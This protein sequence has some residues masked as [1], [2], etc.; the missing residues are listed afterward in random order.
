LFP[1]AVG[2][3]TI[4]SNVIA[5]VIPKLIQVDGWLKVLKIVCLTTVP[6][7]EDFFI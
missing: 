4:N 7:L 5:K 3:T 1:I 2:R 6:K